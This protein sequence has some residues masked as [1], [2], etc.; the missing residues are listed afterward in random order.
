[1]ARDDRVLRRDRLLARVS[2]LS[3]VAI[4]VLFA[5]V[6]VDRM[7]GVDFAPYTVTPCTEE[8]CMPPYDGPVRDSPWSRYSDAVYD[9]VFRPFA[10]Q[11]HCAWARDLLRE[12]ATGPSADLVLGNLQSLGTLTLTALEDSVVIAPGPRNDHW[13]DA[14]RDMP[15]L[16]FFT[17]SARGCYPS[18]YGFLTWAV[19]MVWSVSTNLLVLRRSRPA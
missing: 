1:L 18:R 4:V 2:V 19:F 16:F 11:D 12:Q 5:V 13:G 15:R 17:R 8:T 6:F 3:T 9:P 10:A 14:L 7:R